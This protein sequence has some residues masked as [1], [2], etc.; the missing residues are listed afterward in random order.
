MVIFRWVLGI[1][2]LLLGS[3]MALTFVLYMVGGND[4]WL[5]PTRRLRQWLYLMLL[6]WLNFEIWRR[7]V[8]I[9]VNW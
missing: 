7:V 1:V 6:F 3:G 4:E 2:S 9:L 8:L 5:R